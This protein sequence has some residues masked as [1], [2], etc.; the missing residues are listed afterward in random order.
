MTRVDVGGVMLNVEVAGSGPPVVLLHGFTGSARGWAPIV[1]RLAPEFTTLAMDIVGHGQ[2]DSPEAVEH[3]RMRQVVDD[4]AA[5]LRRAGYERATWLGYSMGG[6][7]A[8]QVAVHRPD[9]VSAL[10]L[11]GASPGL[12]T[13]E[14]REAR[15]A[16]DERLAVMLETEG[17]VP[18][19]DYWQAVPLFA[20]QASLPREVWDRQRE[21]RLR[22][23]T[24]GLANSLR[25]MGTGSQEALY[26]R[27]GELRMPV[28]ATAGELDTRY[29]E[30]ARQMAQA[31]PGATMEV[32]AGGGHAAHLEQPE[33]FTAIVLDFL[34]RIHAA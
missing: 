27:L 5:L 30:T 24:R 28:L 25:G 21:G 16:A 33:R 18:F 22:N 2:S 31:I 17:I 12:R 34:R 13:A 29:T 7:T 9:V 26:E 10:I 3:Y 23:S 4:L 19:V 20:S 8:L 15:V 11:E 14:E 6:R 32:I 1:E